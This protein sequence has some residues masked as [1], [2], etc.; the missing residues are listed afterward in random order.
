MILDLLKFG[1]IFFLPTLI[2]KAFKLIG[3]FRKTKISILPWKPKRI[4]DKIVNSVVLIY[5]IAKLASIFIFGS[6]NFFSKTN[7]RI[8]SPSYVIRNHYRT[9]LENWAGANP[10]VANIVKSLENSSDISGYEEESP[11]HKEI[12]NLKYLSEQL[13][14]KEKKNVYS[15]FGEDA[16]LHC[17]YCTNDYDYLMYLSPSALYEYCTFLVLIGALSSNP[18][19][20][21]WR[22]YGL[23]SVFVSLALEVYGLVF[24]SQ[25]STNTSFEPF[26]AI[27]GDDMLTLRFEKILIVRNIIFVTCLSIAYLLDNEQ[28]LKLETFLDQFRNTLGTSLAFLQSTRIQNAALA[29]DENLSKYVSEA[30]RMN[31]SKL[32]SIISDPSFRQKV[33]E[34][35]HKLNIEEILD[36]KDK[37]IEDLLKIIKKQQ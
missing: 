11:L 10:D 9:Y 4:F 32:A 5:I 37:N 17:D 13:K 7:C 16:F 6:E 34:S 27:F 36:Q 25:S 18:Y 2:G 22:I 19:K 1:I 28:D 24:A 21:N 8:D 31:K 12:F 20:S 23:F 3:E 15:K 33:A 26:D 30:S 35:G 29:I 14:S